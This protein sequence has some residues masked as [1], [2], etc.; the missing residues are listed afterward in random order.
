MRRIKPVLFALAAIMFGTGCLD[1]GAGPVA[2]SLVPE[3]NGTGPAAGATATMC[4]PYQVT[5]VQGGT[6]TPC[7]TMNGILRPPSV[8]RP[9]AGPTSR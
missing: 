6:Y 7:R 8:S 9:R 3:A 2:S 4:Q 1:C 5:N